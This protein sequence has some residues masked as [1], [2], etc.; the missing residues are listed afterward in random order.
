M[1]KMVVIVAKFVYIIGVGSLD[2]KP[3]GIDMVKV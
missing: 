2:L 3:V 1:M